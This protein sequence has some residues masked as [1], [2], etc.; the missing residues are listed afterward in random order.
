LQGKKSKEIASNPLVGT[1]R[2]V[3]WYNVSEDEVKTY[4]LGEAATGYISYS[5]DGFVF[6]QITAANRPL[7]AVNDPFG[8][9]LEED[10]AAMKSHITYAGSYEYRGADVV[11]RVTHASC[12]NW[13]GTEQVRTVRLDGGRLEL[14]AAGAHFQGRPVTAYV[15]WERAVPD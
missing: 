10:A 14:S 3:R 6:V 5:N 1:W 4:P 9:T 12:P 13:V 11:H 2:L 7:Y 8:G 15:L